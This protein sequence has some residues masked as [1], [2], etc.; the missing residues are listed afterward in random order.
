MWSPFL[1]ALTRRCRRP[2]TCATGCT[3][4]TRAFLW[5]SMPHPCS[6]L[7][8]NPGAGKTLLLSTHYLPCLH[9]SSALAAP[10]KAERGDSEPRCPEPQICTHLSHS[11]QEEIQEEHLVPEISRQF[12]SSNLQA[13]V[14]V[15][16]RQ[17]MGFRGWP[18]QPS[19]LVMV[20]APRCSSSG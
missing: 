20:V 9:C 12:S 3:A 13:S 15:R 17:P 10:A 6:A 8:A 16:K 1:P 4:D 11:H 14:R 5:T 18:T 19:R 2:K 7:A